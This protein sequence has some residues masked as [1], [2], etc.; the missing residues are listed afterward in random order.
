IEFDLINNHTHAD[1]MV[2]G[3]GPF[4]FLY[5]TGAQNIL[6][7]EVAK[8][9]GLT[10]EGKSEMR[11]TG[12]GSVDTGV[13]KVRAV[14]FGDV[15]LHDQVFAVLPTKQLFSSNGAEIQGMIGSETFRRF[16]TRIDY[17]AKTFTFMDP[18]TFDPRSAGI[19][20]KVAF[21]YNAVVADGS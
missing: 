16:V 19:P 7:P 5:D 8:E 4:H 2:N 18:K 1:V 10:P 13:T 3:K 15:T 12:E 11:G 6:S 14:Q 20:V 9:V 21:N 17:G